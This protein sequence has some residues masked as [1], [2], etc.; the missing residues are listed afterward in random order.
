MLAVQDFRDDALA[1]LNVKRQQRREENAQDED[2]DDHAPRGTQSKPQNVDD[3]DESD[4]VDVDA[5]P[6]KRE[7][8]IARIK[9]ERQSRGVSVAPRHPRDPDIVM[10]DDL[11]D[12]IW[13]KVGE[14]THMIFAVCLY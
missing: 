4:G 2:Q 14:Q 1:L 9:R 11:C 5:T 6:A 10:E 3:D 8:D 12:W 7:Q 13:W